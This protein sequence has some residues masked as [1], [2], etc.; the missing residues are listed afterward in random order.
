MGFEQERYLSCIYI[1]YAKMGKNKQYAIISLYI[2][3]RYDQS[4]FGKF[5]ELS[6]KG[7]VYSKFQNIY[8]L[9][10]WYGIR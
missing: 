4:I 5:Q 2:R 3:S 7:F 8:F 6:L 1:I 10:F 9:G